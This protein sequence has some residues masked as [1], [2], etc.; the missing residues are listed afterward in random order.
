VDLRDSTLAHEGGDVYGDISLKRRLG[1][2]SYTGYAGHR[3]DS[4]YGGYPYLLQ[5]IPISLTSY[6]GLQYGADLR[7]QTPQKGLL[8][9][10][11]RINEDITGRGASTLFGPTP[12]PYEEHSNQDWINQFYGQYTKGKFEAESVWR[13]YWRNQQV[14]NGLFNVQTDMRGL[15]IAGAP[16]GSASGS[17]PVPT[18]RGSRTASR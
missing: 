8:A 7:W 2:L 5:A 3:Q 1:A 18:T 4:I 9:G 15:Y 6:G 12:V 16:T 11:S 13:R 10:V 14:F 17:R